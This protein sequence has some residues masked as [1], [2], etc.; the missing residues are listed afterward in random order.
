MSDEWPPYRVG[1]P[2]YLHALGPGKPC[3]ERKN[4]PALADEVQMRAS[5]STEP[6][7]AAGN[8]P[9]AEVERLKCQLGFRLPNKPSVSPFGPAVK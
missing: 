5:G 8:D 3:H 2:E 1:K 7:S 6:M 9:A 4:R